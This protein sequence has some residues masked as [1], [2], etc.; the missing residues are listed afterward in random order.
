MGSLKTDY[1]SY[2]QGCLDPLPAPLGDLRATI[3]YMSTGPKTDN[4]NAQKRGDHFEVTILLDQ[5]LNHAHQVGKVMVVRRCLLNLPLQIPDD[6][7]LRPHNH[8]STG[9]TRVRSM[10]MYPSR[11]KR[12][13]GK[14][15]RKRT[16]SEL[17]DKGPGNNF[18]RLTNCVHEEPLWGSEATAH[19]Q[20][21][22]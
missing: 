8:T 11:E 3:S 21:E 16:G 9:P 7:V 20:R 2:S 12:W 10:H 22:N 1:H 4:P 18:S 5:D 17:V 6:F 15:K 14:A 19:T 13:R